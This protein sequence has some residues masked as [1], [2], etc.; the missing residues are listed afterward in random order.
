MSGVPSSEL[1]RYFTEA[2]RWDQDRLASAL[3]SR[4]LAWSAAAVATGLAGIATGAVA[5]LTPLKSTEPFVIRVDRTT[6]AVD[7][8][9]SNPPYIPDAMVP[10]DPEVRD[11]DP[12]EALYGGSADGLRIPLEVA[13]RAFELLRPG[14]V[15]IMEHAENQGDSLPAALA[16][17]GWVDTRDEHDLTGR[18][19]F[20]VAFRPR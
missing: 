8:V 19:R 11:H 9:L 16:R 17:A 18:P 1:K 2:R 13:A 7:V 15:L 20:A 3:R 12:A 10:V 14:G 5:M 6:G 4:R